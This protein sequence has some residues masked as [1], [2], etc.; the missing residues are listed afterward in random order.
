MPP[1]PGTRVLTTLPAIG[2]TT[3]SALLANLPSF[4][5]ND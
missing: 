2:A 5:M 3:L 1:E 4:L